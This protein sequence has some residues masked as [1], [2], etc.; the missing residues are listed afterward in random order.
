MRH[1]VRKSEGFL[2]AL[3]LVAIAWIVTYPIFAWMDIVVGTMLMLLIVLFISIRYGMSPAIFAAIISSLYLNYFFV[4]RI[5]EID[6]G[7]GPDLVALLAFVVMAV[8]VGRL[9]Q[10]AAMRASEA[11][12]G[13]EEIERLY[14]ELKVAFEKT[15]Q[16]EAVKRSEQMK[17][18]LLDA[19]THDLRTPLTAIKA[20]ATTLFNSQS[21]NAQISALSVEHRRALIEVVIEET[22]RLNNFVEELLVFAKIQGGGVDTIESPGSVEDVIGAAMQ[23][24]TTILKDFKI[25]THTPEPEAQVA[26]PRIAAQALYALLDNAAKYSPAGS[27]IEVGANV[28]EGEVL[29]SVD[30]E[31]PGIPAGDRELIFSRFYR[32]AHSSTASSPGLGMGL[33]IARGLV[34]AVGGSIRVA[35]KTGPGTRF[36]FSI[37]RAKGGVE[38]EYHVETADQNPRGG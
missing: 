15:S 13:R 27:Q 16:M 32:R 24:A 33:A 3:L 14:G 35:E 23:R 12:R 17:S 34:G 8:V 22:D 18:A 9:S 21:A 11:E 20:A 4:P 26:N 31:G 5:L 30:D 36:E 29:F 1:W 6:L 7:A 25:V 28:L 19:V 10:R 2:I 37:P 38:Q